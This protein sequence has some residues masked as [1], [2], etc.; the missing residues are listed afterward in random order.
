VEAD[1]EAQIGLTHDIIRHVTGN[2][3]NVPRPTAAKLITSW[4]PAIGN[5]GLNSTFAGGN[6]WVEERINWWVDTSKPGA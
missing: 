2:M 6:I 1:R 5:V 3:Y 4:W